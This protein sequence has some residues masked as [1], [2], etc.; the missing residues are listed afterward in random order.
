VERRV[1]ALL[2]AVALTASACGSTGSEP[3]SRSGPDAASTGNGPTAEPAPTS[4]AAPA[5][6]DASPYVVGF[7]DLSAVSLPSGDPGAVT[8]VVAGAAVDPRGAVNMVVRNNTPDVV[9]RIEVTGTARD[10]EGALVGSGSSQGFQP[11]VVAPG[12]IAYGYVY[13]D[14][15]IPTGSTFEFTVDSEPVDDYFLPVTITEL[16]HTGDTIIG[17][18]LN[19]TG[20]AVNGPIS[21][22]A[23]CF[24]ADGSLVGYVDSY[25]QQDELPAGGTGS[26]SID[27]YG[28]D[29]STGLAAASGYAA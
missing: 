15:D 28:D 7:G 6:P 25:A 12:E 13:F 2:V 1:G 22:E 11:Q 14:S 20:V 16:N 26:F 3:S 4:A 29:C 17:A 27:L 23:I 19:D 8:I 24:G 10:G 9:G 5:A 18:V 21:A